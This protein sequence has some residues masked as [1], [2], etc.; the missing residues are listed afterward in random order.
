MK[1]NQLRPNSRS[2]N[3]DTITKF[4]TEVFKKSFI[5]SS[6]NN[7]NS[8]EEGSHNAQIFANSNVHYPNFLYCWF[9]LN[10][11]YF[12]IAIDKCYK[13]YINGIHYVHCAAFLSVNSDF[14]A[15]HN[16]CYIMTPTVSLIKVV[17]LQIII[18]I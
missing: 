8:S 4:R 11:I 14:C 5:P 13:N 7:R 9:G 12:S 18:I 1:I 3:N 15:S 17:C 6:L 16:L 10:N 2:A